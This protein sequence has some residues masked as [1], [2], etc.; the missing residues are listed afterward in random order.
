MVK[1]TVKKHLNIVDVLDAFYDY[2]GH[3]EF[4]VR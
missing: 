2:D 1:H 3:D 4:E